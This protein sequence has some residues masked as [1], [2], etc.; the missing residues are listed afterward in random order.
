MVFQAWI[1]EKLACLLVSGLGYGS[2]G[3]KS[4]SESK[5]EA[6]LAEL[7]YDVV[8]LG[9]GFAGVNC[10]R[11][12]GR[13]VAKHGKRVG[14][15]SEQNYMV[16]Q[17]ML[18]EVVGSSISPRHVVNP[19][20]RLCRR[21]EVVRGAVKEI[22]I[23]EQRVWID[24]GDFSADIGVRY[25]HLVLALGAEINLSRVPGMPEHSFL[26]RNVG[27]AMILRSTILSR[28]EEANIEM[29]PEVRRRL[30]TFVVVGGGY[31]GVETAGEI[32]D[33][34]DDL[35]R[36]Y[37][38]MEK[39]DLRV[40]LVHSGERILPVMNRRLSEYAEANLRR[41]GLEIVLGS[42]VRAVTASRVFLED[43]SSI[44][45]NTCVSTVGNAP[46]SMV[47]KVCEDFGFEMERGRIVVGGDMRV[48]GCGN[49]WA[50][51]DCAMVPSGGKSDDGKMKY[52]PPTAQ[53][54]QRQGKHVGL[55]IASVMTGG[56]AKP[57]QFK[58]MGELAGI[59]HRSAVAEI[60]GFRFSGMFAWFLW[61]S[62]YLLKL[63]GFERKLR[64]MMD[65]TLDLFFPRDISLLNPRYTRVVQSVYLEEGDVL[66]QAG[67]PAFSLY[68]VKSG[69]IE[70]RRRDGGIRRVIGKGD[71]F[72]DRALLG[73]GV[74]KHHAVATEATELVA[75][76]GEVFLPVVQHSRRL[77]R[78]FRR[79]KMLIEP[80]G[81]V[82]D[83]SSN[84]RSET[85]QKKASELMRG[86]LVS[87]DA[88]QT[89][90]EA[91]EVFQRHSHSS[92]PVVD[93]KG[94][95]QGVI[96]REEVFDG[97]IEGGLELDRTLGEL[98]LRQLARCDEGETVLDAVEKI[99]WS[100]THKC[101][102]VDGDGVLLGMLTVM[103]LLGYEALLEAKSVGR[104]R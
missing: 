33:L 32:L 40:V 38:R 97:L 8:I 31:S 84:L 17:P 4:M 102:V 37:P 74:Y 15:I 18:A 61:R 9:G 25:Q 19:I 80:Q 1:S 59:G 20:R 90:A 29:R 35:H 81:W 44:D 34:V 96:E 73:T 93:S 88:G 11:A 36:Y 92:Y 26:M 98:E 53:Y 75:V 41:R 45:T 94:V 76:S 60:A 72:G 12:L 39:K 3:G 100:G 2:V 78:V 58:G 85:L 42:R 51:G 46:H 103:D 99:A 66:F 104:S 65:W 24:I 70:L 82:D 67:D 28:V 95:L 89:V 47:S 52:C 68:V 50:L 21:A 43:G 7:E 91:L 57:F 23:E 5:E 16:F 86:N 13:L 87:L 55:N 48:P 77:S 10:A 64:V 62:I 83:A 6:A 79:R 22:D 71:Y 49:L 14:L 30:L 101:L 63:P 69:G 27:D 54:A 56:E